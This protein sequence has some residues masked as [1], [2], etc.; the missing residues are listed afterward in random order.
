LIIS[1]DGG[2]YM[3]R[4]G[5]STPSRQTAGKRFESNEYVRDITGFALTIM[6]RCAFLSCNGNEVLLIGYRNDLRTL[7][8][9]CSLTPH[10]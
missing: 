9:H 3:P 8:R 2:A 6:N 4:L 10:R 5:G 1:D 7:A